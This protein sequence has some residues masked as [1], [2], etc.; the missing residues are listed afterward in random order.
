[1]GAGREGQQSREKGLAEACMT[2]VSKTQRV[3]AS[4]GECT[5]FYEMATTTNLHIDVVRKCVIALKNRNHIR[6]LASRPEDG[7]R[8]FFAITKAGRDA[9]AESQPDEV[10][11]PIPMVAYA[12]SKR[13]QLATV[14]ASH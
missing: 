3:L 4:I 10:G 8:A 12:L 11:R 13:S 7:V 9:L 1:V 5:S 14:W 6:R 2:T